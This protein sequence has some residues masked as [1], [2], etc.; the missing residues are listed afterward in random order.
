V[1]YYAI[2]FLIVAIIAAFFGFGVAVSA[3]TGIAKL[4]FY[5]FLIGFA[6]A[7]FMHFSRRRA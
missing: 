3:A 6:L 1:L 2:A 7:L 5:L 4:L